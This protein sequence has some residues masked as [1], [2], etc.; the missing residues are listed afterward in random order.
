M[1]SLST[2][3][4]SRQCEITVNYKPGQKYRSVNQNHLSAVGLA[5]RCPPFI[6]FC[7]TVLNGLLLNQLV[8]AHMVDYFEFITE[9]ECLFLSSIIISTCS[10]LSYF[11]SAFLWNC[12]WHIRRWRGTRLLWSLWQTLAKNHFPIS[13]HRLAPPNL[14]WIVLATCLTCL[15]YTQC[16]PTHHSKVNY[17]PTLS[18]GMISFVFS[19]GDTVFTWFEM[20]SRCSFPR[21]HFQPPS[22]ALLFVGLNVYFTKIRIH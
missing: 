14:S 22:L 4:K 18:S 12:C 16:L 19:K 2:W 5:I 1:N 8:S 17:P 6:G 10:L 13:S 15:M 20:Y 21:S 7:L 11:S 3:Y 9:R